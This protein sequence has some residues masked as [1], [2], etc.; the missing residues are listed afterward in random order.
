MAGS[1]RSATSASARTGCPS[2]RSREAPPP[3]GTAGRSCARPSSPPPDSSLDQAISRLREVLGL[4]RRSTLGRSSLFRQGTQQGFFQKGQ[5]P[6]GAV[7]LGLGLA[8]AVVAEERTAGPL[9]IG[10]RFAEAEQCPVLRWSGGDIGPPGSALQQVCWAI[11]CRC[12]RAFSPPV[13]KSSGQRM[14]S[15]AIRAAFRSGPRACRPASTRPE[16]GAWSAVLGGV[17]TDPR[18]V[19]NDLRHQRP[20]WAGGPRAPLGRPGPARGCRGSIRSR[21]WPAS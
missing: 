4:L 3:W 5:H 11:N 16:R 14:F 17:P 20:E 12:E 1:R 19:A 2:S 8:F 21:R 15:A 13:N 7:T 10:G 9:R 18:G 6:Q